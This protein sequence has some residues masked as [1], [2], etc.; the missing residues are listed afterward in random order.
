MVIVSRAGVEEFFSTRAVPRI[1]SLIDSASFGALLGL[2][3][4]HP[5]HVPSGGAAPSVGIIY[6]EP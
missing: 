4:P 1:V 6:R 5:T 3:C 2:A